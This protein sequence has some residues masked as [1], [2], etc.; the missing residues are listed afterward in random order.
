MAEVQKQLEIKQSVER[1]CD[2]LKLKMK[3]VLDF[4][5]EMKQTEKKLKTEK[6]DNKDV[7]VPVRSQMK[8]EP[9]DDPHTMANGIKEKGNGCVKLK[10]FEGAIFHYT[11]AIETFP[12]D[13]IYYTNRALCYLRLDR[14]NKC[15]EDCNIA[16]SLD[17]QCVKAFYR[18]MQANE[19]LGNTEAAIK[20]CEDVVR[21]EPSTLSH[22]RELDRLK[23]RLKNEKNITARNEINNNRKREEATR[24]VPGKPWS[25]LD[26]E[27]RE[28]DFVD[29]KPH[30]RSKKPLKRVDVA[31]II[32]LPEPIPDHIVDK[33]FNNF[34]GEYDATSPSSS[35]ASV[36]D[37]GIPLLSLPFAPRP[38]TSQEVEDD[39]FEHL[40][41]YNEKRTQ[42][43]AA[44]PKQEVVSKQEVAPKQEVVPKLPPKTKK[45][46]IVAESTEEKVEEHQRIP[47]LPSTNVQFC[48]TWK[49]LTEVTRCGY[50]EA[51]VAA[52]SSVIKTLGPLLENTLLSELLSTLGRHFIA[53]KLPV[54]N[55]LDALATNSEIGILSCF[56][57]TADRKVFAQLMQ[58]MGEMQVD[59]NVLSSIQR[60]F[61]EVV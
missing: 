13:P 42:E 28:V 26:R 21:L 5:R 19:S 41:K 38:S 53:K 31:E 18:R 46:D 60:A 16:I 9:Q 57:T 54:H 10:D 39:V 61:K 33:L 22:R 37:Y 36:F 43:A 51:I 12:D 56:M 25:R 24:G 34:T 8:Q 30:L 1:N 45:V 35:S 55:V 7:D 49:D 14:Q 15:I 50:L 2:E 3:E 6:A 40:A 4:Q 47:D 48:S 44:A 20:D 17:R 27:A 23:N 11:A 59:N 58:Y 32:T 52:N 29:K